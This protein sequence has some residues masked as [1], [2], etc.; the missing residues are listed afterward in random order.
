MSD[1]SWERDMALRTAQE[2]MG[3]VRDE[4]IRPSV[5]FRPNLGQRHWQGGPPSPD[6][7]WQAW[8]QP[9]GALTA[10]SAFGATPDAAMRAFDKVW[11]GEK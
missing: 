6:H 11:V 9:P 8:Y 7:L 2:C 10:V 1:G 3:I 4:M 5:L